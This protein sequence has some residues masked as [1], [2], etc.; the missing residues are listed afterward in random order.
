MAGKLLG[1]R[2]DALAPGKLRQPFGRDCP[3]PAECACQL[4]GSGSRA[5]QAILPWLGRGG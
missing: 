4:A 2:F 5:R 1:E 3:E